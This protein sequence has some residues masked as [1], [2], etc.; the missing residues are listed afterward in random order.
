[1]IK[2]FSADTALLVIDAQRGVNLDAHWGGTG[3]H[4]NNPD[5]ER[6]IGQLLSAWRAAQLPVYFTLHNSREAK[7]PL[8]LALE[9]GKP[10]EG[11]EPKAGEDV[12]VKDVNSGFVGTNLE[13]RLRREGISRLVIAGFFTNMCVET[14][15]RMA[16]NMGFDTYLAHD[17]CAAGNRR[18]LDGSE[19]DANTVHRMSVA[20]LHAEFCTALTSATLVALLSADAAQYHRVQGNE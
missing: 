15:A 9:S 10:I 19:F 16:G 20:N 18:S 3:G 1:M 4:R 17:A 8:K 12:I 6:H 7:S 5:A 2:Q 14:T 11:L 13:L